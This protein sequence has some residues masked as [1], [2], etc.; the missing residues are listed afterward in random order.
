MAKKIPLRQCAGCRE[1][2]TKQ[3]LI[4]IIRT[5]QGEVILDREGRKNGRGVYLCPSPECLK[6][7]RKSSALSRALKTEIPGE[8]YERLDEELNGLETDR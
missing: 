3:E 8:I 1:K 2:K 4:R 7:A 6:K 5:P